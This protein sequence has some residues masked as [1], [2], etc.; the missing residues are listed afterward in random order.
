MD[1]VEEAI[2][3]L[4]DFCKNSLV[5]YHQFRNYDYGIENRSNVSEISKYISHRIIY[6]YDLINRLKLIDINKKFTE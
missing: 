5:S 6:E 1:I 2:N 4:E 3:K